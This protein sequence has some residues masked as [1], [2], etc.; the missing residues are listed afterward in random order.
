MT[1]STTLK[2]WLVPLVAAL[3]FFYEFVQM[4]MPNSLRPDLM[5]AFHIDATQLGLLS[6]CYFWANL[7][8][9]FPAGMIL[10][11][12]STKK[13]MLITLSLCVVGTLLFSQATDFSMAI[14]VR[15]ITGIGSAFCF[16]GCIR[17]AS[18][19]LPAKHMALIAGL[20]VTMA[21]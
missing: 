15:F 8:F 6:S 11:R 10:D 9:L 4:L 7:L 1:Q 14:A 17:L 2:N 3:F 13:V 12:F 16:L 20:I 18:R 19:W 5:Q 21:F